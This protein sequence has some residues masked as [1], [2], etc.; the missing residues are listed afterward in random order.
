M[1]YVAITSNIY[2][3][4]VGRLTFEHPIEYLAEG[5][6]SDCSNLISIIF[7]DSLTEIGD[8]AFSGCSSLTSVTI[9][10]S[11]TYIGFSPFNNCNSLELFVGKFASEDGRCL[12]KEGE[13]IA[14]APAE[15]MEYVIPNNVTKI[16]NGA[17]MNCTGLTSITIPNSVTEIRHMAFYGCSNLTSI[18]IGNSVT[19][20]G[21]D[22]FEGCSSLKEIYCKATTPPSVNSYF[23]GTTENDFKIYVPKAAVDSYKYSFGWW[24]YESN[25]VGYSF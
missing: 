10:D 4:G 23:L 19:E 13:L 9:P 15:L 1:W 8:W 3:G 22:A 24:D 21:N 25:I 16:S 18:T 11:V 5:A 2:M 12:I 17:F 20:I 14:F 7:P 6:F